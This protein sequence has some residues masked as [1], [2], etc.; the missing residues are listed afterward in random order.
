[1]L[2][3]ISTMGW[4]YFA[5][6]LFACGYF[7]VAAFGGW[8]GLSLDIQPGSGYGSSYSGSGGSSYGR[9]SGGSWGGGK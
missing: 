3:N 6:C 8:K 2:K 4:C 5:Y 7:T 1:M 9:S